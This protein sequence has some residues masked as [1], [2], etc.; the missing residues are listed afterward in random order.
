M[1]PLFIFF[2]LIFIS[3]KT[4]AIQ[5]LVSEKLCQNLIILLG[6]NDILSI[7]PKKKINN[8][9]QGLIFTE[10]TSV[11]K[12]SIVNAEKYIDFI[13][14]DQKSYEIAMSKYTCNPVLQMGN[15]KIYNLFS[16]NDL[17]I[18]QFDNL[19]ESKF[20]S[21]EYQIIPNYKKLL[22]IFKKTLSLYAYKI[23]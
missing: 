13:L 23:I 2:S 8:L 16:K 5:I 9:K 12:N 6:N 11:L 1:K 3:L 22:G 20:Y 4:Y 21:H 7:I 10:I 17:K 15:P 14:S 18:I 19:D